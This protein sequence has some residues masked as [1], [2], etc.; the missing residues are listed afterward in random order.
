MTLSANLMTARHTLILRPDVIHTTYFM[1]FLVTLILLLAVSAEVLGGETPNRGRALL[2]ILAAV[3]VSIQ[4]LTMALPAPRSEN[5]LDF[6]IGASPELIRCLND[7]ARD[8]ERAPL[9]Y[10]YLKLIEH[11]RALQRGDA[12][13]ASPDRVTTVVTAPPVAGGN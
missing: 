9:P 13:A 11:F 3:A 1:P 12:A 5:L 4:I 8:P 6:Y 7:P 2:P 10:S